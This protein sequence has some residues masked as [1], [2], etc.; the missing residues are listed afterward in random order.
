M[1]IAGLIRLSHVLLAV[2]FIAGLIGRAAA[3]R[4]ARSAATLEATAAL[5]TLS[6]WFERRL[7][8]PGSMLVLASGA[9]LA[10]MG[11][12]PLLTGRSHPSWLL[13]SLLLLLLPIGFIPTVLV[14]QRARRQAAL[15]AALEAGRRTPELDAALRSF[16]VLRLRMLELGIVA[17]VF[18]LMVLRPF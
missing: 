11:R 1:F 6:E 17:A 10:W 18:V 7:V 5:L 12:W 14:P 9:V 16:T 2:A 3:F 4:Q 15:A 13:V 8:I